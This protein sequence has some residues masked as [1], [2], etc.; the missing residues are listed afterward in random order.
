MV[1]RIPKL[2]ASVLHD[3]FEKC[4]V[5]DFEVGT[6]NRTYIFVVDKKHRVHK[7]TKEEL[8]KI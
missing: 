6:D 1:K 4:T 7:A 3:K 5:I 8:S 2:G